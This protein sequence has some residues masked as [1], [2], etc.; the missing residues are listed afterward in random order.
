M[1]IVPLNFTLVE[2]GP[3]LV[4][5]AV[6]VEAAAAAQLTTLQRPPHLQ[7]AGALILVGAEQSQKL[8]VQTETAQATQ[9]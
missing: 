6:V 7:P 8:G 2:V 3:C 4:F 9:V 5:V 1:V